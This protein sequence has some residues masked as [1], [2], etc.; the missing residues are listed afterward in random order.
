[1]LLRPSVSV[2]NNLLYSLDQNGDIVRIGGE[3]WE[4]GTDYN[5]TDWQQTVSPNSV[6]G[7]PLFV[8]LI[9][10]DVRI[11][12]NSPANFGSGKY[13]GAYKPGGNIGLIFSDGFE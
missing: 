1:M 3:I 4:P 10:N 9:N 12:A 2:S 11:P 13:A 5:F 6:W 8:D 7:N